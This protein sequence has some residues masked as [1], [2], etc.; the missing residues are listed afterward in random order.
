MTQCV[1]KVYPSITPFILLSPA[2]VLYVCVH[3]VPVT[4]E[5]DCARC[6]SIKTLT[7]E[8]EFV[9]SS[10]SG[11]VGKINIWGGTGWVL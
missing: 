11:H 6:L 1:Y 8:K 4:H 2:L 7:S 10:S 3:S 5:P 9:K